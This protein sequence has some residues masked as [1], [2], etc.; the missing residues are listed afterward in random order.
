M[1]VSPR[2]RAAEWALLIF[3]SVLWG[4]SFFFAKI[5]AA[6]LPPLTLV[7][8]RVGL[9]ALPLNSLLCVRGGGLPRNPQLW[10]QFFVMGLLNNLIPFSL[11]F[12]G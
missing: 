11:I 4:G 12:W 1:V 8:A 9:A 10:G 3:L 5:A 7:L 6:A 2:M